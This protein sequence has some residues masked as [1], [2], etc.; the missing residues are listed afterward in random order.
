[1]LSLIMYDCYRPNSAV[2]EMN[3]F[4]EEA[5]RNPSLD[6]LN[7]PYHPNVYRSELIDQG[8]VGRGTSGHSNGGSVDLAIIIN[9]ER[10]MDLGYSPKPDVSCVG[11]LHD[12]AI[13]FGT[14]WDCMDPRSG[15][16]GLATISR[17]AKA[18]RE[19]LSAAMSPFFDA[20]YAEWWH[21]SVKGNDAKDFRQTDHT[22]TE[23]WPTGRYPQK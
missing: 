1:M 20:Y 5:Q 2:R 15:T 7:P 13:D 3:R 9:K 16:D 14:T 8:Y 17:T 22:S 12:M 18:N 21:W 6:K 10:G 11:A 4:V 19:L 23:N